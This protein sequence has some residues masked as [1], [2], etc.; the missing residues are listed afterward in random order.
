MSS[1]LRVAVAVD[2]LLM[3]CGA[4]SDTVIDKRNNILQPYH[5]GHSTAISECHVYMR[6]TMDISPHVCV[7]VLPPEAKKYPQIEQV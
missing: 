2:D 4:E 5:Q 1:A 7:T 3:E 6:P